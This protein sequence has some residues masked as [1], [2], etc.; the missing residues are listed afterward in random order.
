MKLTAWFRKDD[1]L[2]DLDQRDGA[3]RGEREGKVGGRSPTCA[4]VL[5]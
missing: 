5:E 2:V 3:G 1:T 4:A